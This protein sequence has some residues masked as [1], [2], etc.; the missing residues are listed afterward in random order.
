MKRLWNR[1]DFTFLK[2]DH[3]AAELLLWPQ[4]FQKFTP[5]PDNAIFEALA[6]TDHKSAIQDDEESLDPDLSSELYITNG[7]ELDDAYRTHGI[8]G[9]TP[10]GTESRI[11]GV[12]GF[13]FEDD[14]Q[15]VQE[16]FLRHWE[17]S[18]DLAESADDPD[19][20]ESHLG[21]EMREFY[22]DSFGVSY[23]DPQPVQ[24]TARRSLGPVKLHYR[25]NGEREQTAPTSEFRAGSA[26]T[27]TRASTTTACAARSRAPS[28][29]TR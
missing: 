2:N 29:V 5:T 10:E 26:T 11:P 20:P 18:L 27:R 16:E 19:E 23:G 21:N 15:E 6:G 22:V 4:G 28:P 12:T 13:E 8:L 7:D 25:I 1:V 9:F 3:T 17:F 24:V 14:E